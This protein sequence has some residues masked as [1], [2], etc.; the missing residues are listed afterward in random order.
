MVVDSDDGMSCFILTL[1]VLKLSLRVIGRKLARLRLDL[2]TLMC[3]ID[4][5][6]LGWFGNMTWL[7]GRRC[8][9]DREIGEVLLH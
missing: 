6:L 4:V 3:H 5:L 7:R 1:L 2:V 9:S 8:I